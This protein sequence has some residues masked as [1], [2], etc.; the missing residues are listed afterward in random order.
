MH[1]SR[2]LLDLFQEIARLYPSYLA[3][4]T[5]NKN[6]PAHS[7]IVS[8]VPNVLQNLSSG[9]SL[10]KFEGSAGKGNMTPAPWM[11]VYHTDITT[12][13]TDGFYVVYLLSLSMKR[14]V[15]EIGLGATQFEK[16]FG[17]GQ[18]MLAKVEEG[19]SLV[20]KASDYILPKVLSPSTLQRISSSPVQ[21]LDGMRSPKHEAYERCSIYSLSYDLAATT[22]PVS[23]ENDYKEILSLYCEMVGSPLVPEVEDLPWTDVNAT[24]KKH[25]IE[26]SLFVPLKPKTERK[27]GTG[28]GIARK[29][30]KQ[31]D[32]VGREGERIVFELEKQKLEDLG[33]SDLAQK[34]IWHRDYAKDRTPGWDITSYDESGKKIFIEVKATVANSIT[35]IQLTSNE[36]ETAAKPNIHDCYLIYLVTS[37]LTDPKIEVLADPHSFVSQNKLEI[38][39]ATWVL[40]LRK[41]Q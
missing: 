21:L 2:G 27:T 13:A 19:A 15:L 25:T 37:A 17:T 40:D 33:R 24:A 41:K 34:V 39:V 20:R 31:S 38:A 10:L 3:G 7:L 16:R 12:S 1:G 35:S 23:F 9:K 6:D 11:A 22:D 28:S 32:K 8:E 14:L 36:W 4:R 29:Y 18:K 5:T 30:S 26:T